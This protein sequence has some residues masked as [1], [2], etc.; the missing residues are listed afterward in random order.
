[1][2][3]GSILG[4]IAAVALFLGSIAME[5]N[6]YF[7]F[8]S[9]SSAMM[10][11]GGTLSAAF[12]SFRGRY[13]N[14]ALRDVIRLFSG[15]AVAREYLNAEIGQMIRWGYLVKKEGV[16]ELEKEIAN[17]KDE[18]LSYAVGLV[19]AGYSAE[20]VRDM[21]ESS[22]ETT[23]ERMIVPVKILKYMGSAAPAFG[24]IG[25]LVGLIVMLN[26]I[27]GSPEQLGGGLATALLTTLYGVL[28]ARLVFLPAATKSQQGHEITRYRNYV[29]LEGF[30]M[31]SDDKSPRFIQDRLN[32]QLDQ[33][34]RYDI[35]TQG[36]GG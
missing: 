1:M 4:F 12:M 32:S 5:T 34:I 24:M 13:V 10:V 17:L 35:D 3:L 26:N 25:T 8:I 29:M 23:Y 6:N 7:I 28:L 20:D 2:A 33:K 21:L 18:F 22:V 30:V 27:G 31:L 19:V 11:V 14:L 9:A 15:Y 36:K 16:P